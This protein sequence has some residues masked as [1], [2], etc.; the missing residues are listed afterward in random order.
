MNEQYLAFLGKNPTLSLAEIKPYAEI[1]HHDEQIA[2][3]SD[4]KIS[5]LRQLPKQPAQLWLDQMGGIIR[6]AQVIS[7]NPDV[8][9]LPDFLY[10]KLCATNKPGTLSFGFTLIGIPTEL[11]KHLQKKLQ[12]KFEEKERTIRWINKDLKPLTS[13][14][15]FGEKL[16]RKG[17]EFVLYF[18]RQNLYLAQTFANQ[19]LRNY[20]LRDHR[21]PWRDPKMGMIPPKLAQILI[22]LAEPTPNDIIYDPFCGS[23]TINFEAS[24]LGHQT[25]G[26]DLN[27]KFIQGAQKNL[28][29]LAQ[30]FRFDPQNIFRQKDATQIIWSE[31]NQGVLVTEGYLGHNFQTRPKYTEAQV[32]SEHILQLWSKV[33]Q[34][35]SQ[36]PI[37]RLSICVPNWQTLDGPLSITEKI[38]A[39][40]QG[41][42]YF[43][44]ALFAGQ[45]SYVY[46]REHSFVG[47]E[48]I[49]LEK[50]S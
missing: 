12:K 27:A 31:K 9:H 32:E 14:Q 5:N 17:A 42:G 35:L 26:S 4:L 40:F 38:F 45:K 41:F 1:Q 50:K 46:K 29:F 22:N 11:K 18:N 37:K 16:L 25:Q 21:K 36:S 33:S 47:R 15:I 34:N 49:V 24:I 19:N 7:V 23:G 10:Q 3:L 8:D 20:E 30:K 6:L 39:K 43:P 44:L 13:A 48:I 2:V 28:P